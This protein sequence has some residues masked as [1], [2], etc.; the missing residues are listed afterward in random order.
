M[1]K[2]E[3]E[4]GT[5]NKENFWFNKIKTHFELRR[6]DWDVA[7]DQNAGGLYENIKWLRQYTDWCTQ[8]DEMGFENGET[9][10]LVDSFGSNPRRTENSF[11]N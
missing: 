10:D 4:L 2:R 11:F 1:R 8:R 7:G 3:R 9:G 5:D 6:N